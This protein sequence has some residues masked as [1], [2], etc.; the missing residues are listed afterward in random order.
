MLQ[1]NQKDNCDWPIEE[2]VSPEI[3]DERKR[4]ITG[5]F[6]LLLL[7]ARSAPYPIKVLAQRAVADALGL[8]PVHAT[9][10]EVA[11]ALGSL[12]FPVPEL[13]ELDDSNGP[14][15]LGSN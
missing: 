8:C 13:A 10:D 3:L 15:S 1:R 5:M 14:D 9:R 11:I 6:R 4:V 12:G 2:Y 7:V